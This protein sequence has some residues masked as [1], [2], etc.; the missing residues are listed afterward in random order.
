MHCGGWRIGHRAESEKTTD[1]WASRYGPT[2]RWPSTAWS[3]PRGRRVNAAGHGSLPLRDRCRQRLGTTPRPGMMSRRPPACSAAR[4]SRISPDKP[5]MVSAR[6]EDFSCPS[7]IAQHVARGSQARRPIVVP[8]RELHSDGV[9]FPPPSRIDTRLTVI[10]WPLAEDEELA[11]AVTGVTTFELANAAPALVED[12]TTRHLAWRGYLTGGLLTLYERLGP[13]LSERGLSAFYA[14]PRLEVF[15]PCQGEVV[16]LGAL[17]HPIRVDRADWDARVAAADDGN[18][19]AEGFLRSAMEGAGDVIEQVR[20]AAQEHPHPLVAPRPQSF[21]QRAPGEVE[22]D[23]LEES[24][25][26]LTERFDPEGNAAESWV[27]C[28]VLRWRTD[29]VRPARFVSRTSGWRTRSAGASHSGSGFRKK[30]R[31]R[32]RTPSTSGAN[33]RCV[34]TRRSTPRRWPNG[35]LR[36]SCCGFAAGLSRLWSCST[37]WRQTSLRSLPRPG[38]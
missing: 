4:R 15:V 9:E 33:G 36:L 26:E 35:C 2:S 19:L 29:F 30:P 1:A 37:S 28:R 31:T 14:D 22:F 12:G 32:M 27:S 11:A 5:G 18:E 13:L 38:C 25:F 23:L 7:A 6:A 8:Y 21:G 16:V 3:A 10:D 20:R 17:R 24:D 34:H